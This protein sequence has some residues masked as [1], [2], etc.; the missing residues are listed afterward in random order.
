MLTYQKSA[1][2]IVP[3]ALHCVMLLSQENFVSPILEI[4]VTMHFSDN[5]MFFIVKLGKKLEKQRNT[6]SCRFSDHFKILKFGDPQFLLDRKAHTI[7]NQCVKLILI[8]FY[9]LVEYSVHVSSV[10]A[11]QILTIITTSP[12]CS[13]TATKLRTQF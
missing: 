12:T 6:S 3:Q 9:T 5:P 13:T 10:K 7:Y 2:L 11:L 1:L 4:I 8:P